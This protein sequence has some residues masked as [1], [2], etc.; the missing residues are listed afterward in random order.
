MISFS[1]GSRSCIGINLA[2]AELYTTFAHLVRRFDLVNDGTTDEDMDWIDTFVPSF[3]GRL[4]VKLL[5]VE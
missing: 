5:A 3:K 1:R 2:Y 4:R